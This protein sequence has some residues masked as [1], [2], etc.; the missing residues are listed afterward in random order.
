MRQRVERDEGLRDAHDGDV[1]EM[2]H[3]AAREERP[4]RRQGAALLAILFCW[5]RVLPAAGIYASASK[6]SQSDSEW[7][8]SRRS[9]CEPS[10]VPPVVTARHTPLRAP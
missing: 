5:A 10:S 8:S 6:S 4:V 1:E 3:D 2:L 7:M 9:T